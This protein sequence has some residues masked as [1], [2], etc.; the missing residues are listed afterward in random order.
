MEGIINQKWRRGRE[1]FF[2]AVNFC[3]SQLRMK[4]EKTTVDDEEGGY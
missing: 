2:E 3:G 4:G 1:A